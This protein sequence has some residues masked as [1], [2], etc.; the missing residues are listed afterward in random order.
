MAFMAW[1]MFF[2]GVI[3]GLV[4]YEII[5]LIIKKVKRKRLKAYQERCSKSR[6]GGIIP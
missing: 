1:F 2:S 4:F 3:V 6:F 5:D